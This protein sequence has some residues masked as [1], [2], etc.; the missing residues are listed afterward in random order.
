MVE[1]FITE[2]SEIVFV[3]YVIMQVWRTIKFIFFPEQ[4]SDIYRTNETKSITLVRQRTIPTEWLP[5]VGEV[6]VNFCE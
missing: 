1:S 5:L 4:T 3:F 2:N 6:S